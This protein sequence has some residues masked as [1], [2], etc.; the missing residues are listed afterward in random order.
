MTAFGVA[1]AGGVGRYMSELIVEGETTQDLPFVDVKRH[2]PYQNG[3]H[4][5]RER[6]KE[7]ICM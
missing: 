5:L 7:V 1:G 2:S 4:F 3:A 6:S